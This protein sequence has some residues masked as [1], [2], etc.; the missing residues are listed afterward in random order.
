MI[1]SVRK[2]RVSTETMAPELVGS[3][4][5]LGTF[6]YK[7]MAFKSFIIKIMEEEEEY[8]NQRVPVIHEDPKKHK[9]QNKQVLLNLGVFA[10]LTALSSLVFMGWLAKKSRT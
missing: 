9:A 10:L 2:M 8:F 6:P 7:S 5:P 4:R 1:I 3:A